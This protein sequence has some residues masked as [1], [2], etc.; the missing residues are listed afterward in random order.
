M[1]GIQVF[2]ASN[3][4]DVKYSN[5]AGLGLDGSDRQAGRRICGSPKFPEHLNDPFSPPLVR[6]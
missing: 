1:N 6:I 3:L 2:S 4:N 5:V